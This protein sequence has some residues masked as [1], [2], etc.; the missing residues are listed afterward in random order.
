MMRIAIVVGILC[1][2]VFATARA[3]HRND[4]VDI[5]IGD[6][7]VNGRR[8]EIVRENRQQSFPESVV[9]GNYSGIAYLGNDRYAIVNDKSVSDGFVVF[10]IELDSVSGKIIRITDEGFHSADAANCDMEGIAF[11]S[12]DSTI[13]VCGEKDNRILEYALNGQL[14]GREIFLPPEFKDVSSNYGLE[15]LTYNGATRRFWITTESTLPIDGVP[16]SYGNKVRNR[17]RLQCFDDRL[18]PAGQYFYEMDEPM[19]KAAPSAYAMGVSALCALDDGRLII[20]EREFAVTKRKLGSF[21][22]CCLYVV[23]PSEAK[24]GDILVKTELLKFKTSLTLFNF[25]LANYEGLCAGPKL[26]DGSLVL[27][28]V[29]DSQNQHKGVLK[30]WFKTVVIKP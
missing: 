26:A 21:V 5:A 13:F 8:I 30:D 20:L 3:E 27:I 1:T 4:S 22:R 14:T 18:Q 23:N 29:S 12:P 2:S 7:S 24:P 10:H 15:S 16:A 17:L 9:A 11:F 6:T 28:L 19:V 25:S